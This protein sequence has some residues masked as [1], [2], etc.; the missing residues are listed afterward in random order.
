MRRP[1]DAPYTAAARPAG[2]PPTTTRSKQRSGQVVDRQAEVLGQLARRRTAQHRPGR[3]H[4]RQVGSGDAELAQ[5]AIDVGVAVG[6]EPLVRDA[7]AGQEL[8]DLRRS[9][10]RTGS[11]SPGSR[12]GR[13]AEQ[14]RS[15]G[16]ERG[17]D[18][19]AQRRAGS[20]SHAA[21][22]RAGTTRTSPAS[23]TRAD[24]KTRRPVSR[25]SS[26]RKR[27]GPW[28]AIS[29]SSPCGTDNDLDATGE[30]HE[31]VVGHVTLPVEELA[32]RHDLPTSECLENR[33][34]RFA[35]D[36]KCSLIVIRHLAK[37]L[38]G[39]GTHLLTVCGD[40]I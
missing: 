26:P 32:G 39:R 15:P 22:S 23:T 29:R 19:V 36:G 4:H 5:Q 35:E 24:T 16:D 6:V 12:C 11:R 2:P 9:P 27:P 31:E 28:R 13:T 38:S 7:A 33:E 34:L 20:R 17:Q 25:F 40:M 10:A 14:H 30:D 8:A 21:A 3:D 18:R 37:L 1:S